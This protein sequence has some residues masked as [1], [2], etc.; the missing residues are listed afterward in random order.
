M[1]CCDFDKNQEESKENQVAENQELPAGTKKQLRP[2]VSGILIGA[3]S[4]AALFYGFSNFQKPKSFSPKIN[5]GEKQASNKENIADSKEAAAYLKFKE[6]KSSVIPAGVPEIYGQELGV[7]FD[8]AQDAI[9]KVAP[10]DLTYGKNKISLADAELQR[11]IK[12]GSLTA[13]QYCCGAKTLVQENGEAACG[14]EHSQMMR[15]LIAY[16][17]KNNPE[18]SDEQI[19]SK[20]NQWKAVFF[21]KQTLTAKLQELEKAGDNDIGAILEEFPDFLPQMVGGC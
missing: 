20:T 21:P 14:C 19:L 7:S 15:G 18:M 4:G 16:L 2:F 3:I 8:K 10:F 1:H 12:I 5:L 6:I 17:I 9:N 13:C 11:Y